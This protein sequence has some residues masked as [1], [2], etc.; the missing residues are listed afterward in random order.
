MSLFSALNTSALGYDP[1][2]ITPFP[3]SYAIDNGYA[4][5]QLVYMGEES[6]NSQYIYQIAGYNGSSNIDEV[7]RFD[8]KN[9][10]WEIYDNTPTPW[11]ETPTVADPS[12][13]RFMSLLPYDD[14]S[15]TNDTVY[16]YDPQAKSFSTKS[17]P[18]PQTD[19]LRWGLAEYIPWRDTVWALAGSKDSDSEKH[20]Y[21][22]DISDNSWNRLADYPYTLKTPP[23]GLDAG[24]QKMYVAYGEIYE[25][26]RASNNWTQLNSNGN[27]QSSQGVGDYVNDIFFISF[28][29][30]N[31]DAYD[32]RTDT[33]YTDV[34]T[35][36]NGDRGGATTV[37]DSFYF[38]DPDQSSAT[39]VDSNTI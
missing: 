25:Y 35:S 34:D 9:G 1:V 30:D 2:D 14:G 15:Q 28:D 23:A 22:Y 27:L 21:E 38:V 8:L 19:Q 5:E 6:N 12:R 10:G 20:L 31:V 18:H 17:A 3:S 4:D 7:Y 16:F 39:T 33:Y 32:V 13:E 24:R 11:R 29:G 36:S 37:N 26:D